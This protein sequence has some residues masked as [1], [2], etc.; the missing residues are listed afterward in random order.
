MRRSKRLD[1]VS[2]ARLA[3]V[4][5]RIDVGLAGADEGHDALR[6]N[7]HVAGIGDERVEADVEAVRQFDLFQILLDRVGLGAGLRNGRNIRRRAGGLHS[8]KLF[9]IAWIILRERRHRG[10]QHGCRHG[11]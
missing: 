3:A 6:P 11:E 9:Q 5:D 2:D 4:G 10:Q 7:R 8:S 1:L